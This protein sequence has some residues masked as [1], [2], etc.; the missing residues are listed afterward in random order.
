MLNLT[1]REP[2]GDRV[3]E[4]VRE[5]AAGGRL[6]CAR[7]LALARRLGVDPAVIGRAADR[8]GIKIEACQLGCFC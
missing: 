5:A 3:E 2:A 4:A 8:L 7:G 6:T 1:E